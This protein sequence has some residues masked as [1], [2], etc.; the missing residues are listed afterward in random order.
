MP[1]PLLIIVLLFSPGICIAQQRGVD[2]TLIA[3]KNHSDRDTI[4]LQLLND[5]AYYYSRTNPAKGLKTA[6]EAIELAQSLQNQGSLAS[7]YSYKGM[8][9]GSLGE[10]SLALHYY[11]LAL[12]FHQ[13]LGNTLRIATSYNNIAI[14]LVNLSDYSK[15]LEYH[16]KAF[17]I[18]SEQNDSTRMANSLNNIAVVYLY[19]NDYRQS[20]EFN[21][22]AL[23]ILNNQG[24]MMAKANTLLN[25]G[26]VYKNLSSFE[27]ALAYQQEAF[28]IYE[29]VGDN[30]GMINTL[31]NIGNIYHDIDS[32]SQAL[33]YYHRSLEL[34]KKTGDKRGIA[35]NT[36]NIGIV[37]SGML[38]Y[39]KA[40]NNFEEALKINE[41]AGDKKRIAGDLIEIAK[42]YLSAPDSLPGLGNTARRQ[43]IVLSYGQRS[44]EIGQEI[45][46]P[47][48]QR[49]AWN[50]LSQIYQK[51]QQFSKALEAYKNHIMLRDS[52]INMEVKNDVQKKEMEFEFERK[53]IR[54][55]ALQE[56]QQA[57][58]TASIR[59]HRLIRNTSVIIG[60]VVLTAAFISFI[61]YK[62]KRDAT[63]KQRAAEFKLK[64]ASNEM[65]LLLL[66]MNPHFIF[67]SLNSINNYID[68]NEGS[69]ATL[70]TT[71]FA[72]LMRLTLE[73]SRK[74]EI[75]LADDLYL[76]E[77]YLELEL[78]RL[79]G[80]FT[81]EIKIDNEIDPELTFVPPMLM[82]P[83]VENSIWHGV[84]TKPSGGYIFINIS[85]SE[86]TLRYIV[87]DNGGGTKIYKPGMPGKTS[88]GI[89]ITE[90][91]IRMINALK[92]GN[93]EMKLVN[94][95]DG[96]RAEILLPFETE[97]ND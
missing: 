86:N 65:D 83:F 52:I 22:Q 19:L 82:Q 10:D 37:Y 64:E 46:S 55:R 1:R 80:S 49:D 41:H 88:L 60:C 90:S 84:S 35:S 16:K 50:V 7:A 92:G 33:N 51:K 14:S 57:E 21:L 44:L 91:R 40:L 20:L 93:A 54:L 67:N 77:Q 62:R 26:L 76:L 29:E 69:K 25:I 87:E 5:L 94:L 42:I 71:R 39:S 15:A 28:S 32:A 63:E 74:K 48:V 72:R 31:G 18:F 13:Q 45:G 11:Q 85:R 95:K 70:F 56:K 34:S 12:S 43:N 30:H 47:D 78:L 58:A 53:E 9:Y 89:K 81:Y 23:K 27:K 97:I 2:S 96:V 24:A 73:N 8:N 59:R 4:R 61:F 66:Q 3:L 75:T 36:S 68:N 79:N 38:E 6:D 17:R